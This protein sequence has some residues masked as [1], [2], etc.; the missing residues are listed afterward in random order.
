VNAELHQLRERCDAFDALAN[1]LR[2]PDG[3]LSYRAMALRDQLHE[4]ARQ[5]P[6]RPS[7][8]ERVCTALIDRDEVLRQARS[9]LEKMRTLATNWEA[10]VAGVRNENRWLRSS[11]EGAQVQQ[12]QAEERARALEQRAKEADDLKAALDVKVAALAA[13]EDQLLRERTARQ[14]A[15][16][17]L[18]QEQATLADARSALEQERVTR[19]AA[20]KSLEARNTEFSKI[21]G[22]L[23]VLSINSASQ[24]LALHEQGETVKGL[25]RT[26]EAERRALEVERKQVEGKSLLDSCFA[27][28]PLEGSHPFSDSFLVLA[29]P[30][31]RTAL[32]HETE[33]AKALQTSY[34]SSEQEL[35]ELHNAALETCRV[36]EEGE[37]QAGSSL[38][39]RLRALSG[40]V[41]ER[42]RRALRLGVHKALGVKR[43]AG[44]AKPRSWKR[45]KLTT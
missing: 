9:D 13:S 40:H 16:G 39:S 14:G 17:R 37:A 19:E 44:A 3:W 10:E 27:G 29:T 7:S 11:L 12:R 23:M 15:E 34:N 8:L 36:V 45:T 38:A 41:T 32:G 42:M 31:L 2:S 4:S 30:G 28:F 21:E 25:E 26:V 22:E 5:A 24:E 43:L 6:A 1:A 18:Q 20:Q 35:Q 33:R